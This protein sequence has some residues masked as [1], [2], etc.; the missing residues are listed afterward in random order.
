MRIS[1]G[2]FPAV[3]LNTVCARHAC[4]VTSI[5]EPSKS[6]GSDAAVGVQITTLRC[7]VGGPVETAECTKDWTAQISGPGVLTVSN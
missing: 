2:A 4:T 6:F 7:H 1:L 3:Y 5:I